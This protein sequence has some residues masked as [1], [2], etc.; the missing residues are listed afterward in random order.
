MKIKIC[1]ITR[2]ED[3]RYS[4]GAGADYLGFIQY[5]ESPRYISPDRVKEILA[6]IY[7]PAP[8][9]VFVNEEIDH[10]NE[11]ASD[12]GFEFVQLHG[13]ETPD[14]C[15]EVVQPVIRA[16]RVFPDTTADDLRRV[17]DAYAP[18]VA[19]FLFDTGQAGLHGGTG[20]TF[21]WQVAASLAESYPLFLAGGI[22]A[23][24]V[25]TAAEVVQ[26]YAVDASS[27]LERSPGIKDIDKLAD[28]FDA[29][30]AA[31]P[32]RF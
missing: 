11:L 8:V 13:D 29:A 15:A 19:F 2:L 26:P 23:A 22:S 24:N 1:G 31:A 9:G 32:E 16:L 28:F 17:M 25:A 3:A 18:H 21:D 6:W 20:R 12:A 10:V 5:K 7:G 27:S 4:A 30:R 14:Q